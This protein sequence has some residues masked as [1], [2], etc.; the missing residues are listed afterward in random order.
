[1]QV[2][3]AVL[4]LIAALVAA[5]R[6]RPAHSLPDPDPDPKST[7]NA[8]P[9]D[10]KA[11][12]DDRPVRPGLFGLGALAIAVLFTA[13]TIFAYNWLNHWYRAAELSLKTNSPASGQLVTLGESGG[14]AVGWTLNGYVGQLTVSGLGS[15]VVMV[16]VPASQC[17]AV[18]ASL[19]VA[20]TAQGIFLPAPAEFSWSTA[21][22]LSSQGNGELASTLELEPSATGLGAQ[23]LTMSVTNASPVL[24]FAPLN[25]A[26]LTITVARRHYTQ[27]FSGFT[28]C[29]GLAATVSSPGPAAPSF[30]LTGVEGLTVTASAPTAT[31]QGFTSQITLNP[32]GTS[33]QGPATALSLGSAGRQ[34]SATLQVAP[35]TPALTVVN[36][37]ATSVMADGNQLVPSEWSRETDVFGPVLGGV[38]TALVVTPLGL[39]LG[40]LTD[41]LKRWPGPRRRV[42]RETDSS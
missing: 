24:C 11:G 25:Q 13:G 27:V 19:G 22:S 21:Q 18:I 10:G 33:V 16:P 12:S 38:V 1:M 7:A 26:T 4:G 2:G 41:A 35:G 15:T 20:C 30:E 3:L 14:P 28:P 17:P 37:S 5:R 6:R 42:R 36:Q 31:L 23:S 9:S 39:S 32:G 40:V 29:D 34:L 8:S